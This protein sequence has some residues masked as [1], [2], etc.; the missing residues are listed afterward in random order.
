M[1]SIK[2]KYKERLVRSKEDFPPR[3]EDKLFNLEIVHRESKHVVDILEED[4][5]KRIKILYADFFKTDLGKKRVRKI[6][7]EGSAGVGKTTL[8]MS[9]SEDWANEELFQQFTL[10]LLLPLRQR[11]VASADSLPV[12]LSF[13]HS[14]RDICNS[15]ASILEKNQGENLLIV[16]DGWDEL[17]ESKKQDGSFLYD[18]LLGEQLP[19][20]SVIL[21]TR[22]SCL[23]SI[24][25]NQLIDRFVEV[26]GFSKENII[27]YFNAELRCDQSKVLKLFKLLESNPLLEDI[28]KIPLNC[29]IVCH[30]W[31]YLD[32]L[33]ST[34]T[35]L[36][37]KIIL[38]FIYRNV[39]IKQN[40][41]A[42]INVLQNFDSIPTDLTESWWLLCRFAFQ[43]IEKN[44]VAFS[45]ED[46]SD[47]FPQGS[48]L[49]GNIFRFGLLQ[50]T[51]SV[52]DVGYG[53]SYHFI[54]LTFQEYLAALHIAKQSPEVQQKIC[55]SR[56][57]SQR[58]SMVWRFFCGI[59]FRNTD[60]PLMSHCLNPATMDVVRLLIPKNQA[61]RV[62]YHLTLLHCAYEAKDEDVTAF[63][64]EACKD[65][66]YL[67]P[68]SVFDCSA[69]SY[70]IGSCAIESAKPLNLNYSNCGI[71][72]KQVVA[73][74]DS[75]NKHGKLQIIS[76]DLR[77]N[78]LSEKSIAY[79]FHKCSGAFT[80]MKYL[81]LGG[82]DIGHEG[83][84][85]IMNAIPRSC[86]KRLDM[87]RNPIGT[88]G[89]LKMEIAIKAGKLA[90]LKRLDIQ[91]CLVKIDAN[92]LRNVLKSLSAH[93]QNLWCLNISDNNVDSDCAEVIGQEIS[94]MTKRSTRFSLN[95]N[96]M[97][98]GDKALISFVQN[99]ES[100]CC[101]DLL[102]LENNDIHAMGISCLA[103]R[104]FSMKQNLSLKGNPL[105]LE[106]VSVIGTIL[107]NHQ[108]QM[109][110][111][112]LSKCQLTTHYGTVS[113][114]SVC[115]DTRDVGNSL[116]HLPQCNT[117]TTL[118][119]DNNSFNGEGIHILAGL[120]HL[121]PCL[122]N[123]SCISC[124][125]TSHDVQQFLYLVSELSRNLK[126]WDLANN[127]IDDEG[128]LSLLQSSNLFHDNE[129]NIY[130]WN[131]PISAEM[132]KR[133]DRS[134][135]SE[136]K[137]E[138]VSTSIIIMI[139]IV[140]PS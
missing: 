89:L 55:K 22:P 58:Y 60:R 5:T 36:Y 72:D 3:H 21:T 20:A 30:L 125:I 106:G 77:N 59:A 34:M 79:L 15:V 102:T 46:L 11:R 69:I 67:R 33:P 48:S 121:C 19:F 139:V 130:V 81:Y 80:I 96:K 37:T 44:I 43:A 50:S 93:C 111:L 101:F 110:T 57:G 112:T 124:N 7:V 134:N 26:C 47:F 4:K 90:N 123:L 128:I 84:Q 119:L 131:N 70:I 49:K 52:L 9:L 86:F 74:A 76:L 2:R 66:T 87:S 13:L 10:L 56:A 14:S 62:A 132:R 6:L 75:L 127:R 23:S 38:C 136:W 54:H 27:A 114:D 115:K 35:E 133:V 85:S 71:E 40:S 137:I 140:S 126:Q 91:G 100:E 98:F 92:S 31:Q 116:F 65:G 51:E 95:L 138:S 39:I 63:I 118:K 24:Y 28:C 8:C 88:S 68:H 42:D 129:I 109:E 105:G 16:A 97:I 99:L 1:T 122:E 73:L 117:I 29:V 17:S 107:S 103:D 64:R 83:L 32:E 104:I 82:N 12:L 45:E 25:R 94:T 61:D 78:K 108:C 120:I 113:N 18:L 53:V 41:Y 135:E